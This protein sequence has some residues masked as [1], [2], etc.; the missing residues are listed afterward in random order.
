MSI[1]KQVQ[2]ILNQIRYS[3]DYCGGK[4]LD[5]TLPNIIINNVGPLVL[6]LEESQAKLIIDQQCRLAPFGFRDQTLYDIRVS[7]NKKK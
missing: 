3:G 1:K 7:S 2:T 4:K 6:P 5:V